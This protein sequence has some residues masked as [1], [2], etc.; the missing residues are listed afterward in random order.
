MNKK[1]FVP[2][3][4]SLELKELGFDERCFLCYSKEGELSNAMTLDKTELNNIGFILAPTYSQIFDWFEEHF[5][6]YVEWLIEGWGDDECI[7]KPSYRVFIW[8]VGK[9]KPS[10]SDDLGGGT[11]EQM[12]P[13][14]LR[15][16]IQIAKLGPNWDSLNDFP[17]DEL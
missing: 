5:G 6:L 4:L 12:K 11:R 16:L 7:S 3:E 9:P 8:E 10:P 14:I 1:D 17:S 13:E 15:G 2:Y